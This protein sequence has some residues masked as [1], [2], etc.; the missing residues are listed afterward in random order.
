[1]GKGGNGRNLGLF[2]SLLHHQFFLLSLADVPG[3]RASLHIES[4]QQ[5]AQRALQELLQPLH[6]HDRGRFARI[7][8]I[9]STL[10]SIS[11][12][13]I[14]DLFFRPVIGNADIVELIAEMLYE[15]TVQPLAPSA[16]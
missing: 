2:S 13:L 3:L 12:A 6:P 15:I 7:L 8:L 14:T 11:P 9:S 5:E 10:K 1:M 16:H 4:L